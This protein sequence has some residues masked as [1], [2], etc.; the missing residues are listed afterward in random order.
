MSLF[1][2]D[3]FYGLPWQSALV[4]DAWDMLCFVAPS[5]ICERN[6]RC[7]TSC[8]LSKPV[9]QIACTDSPCAAMT[10]ATT[11]ITVLLAVVTATTVNKGVQYGP[12]IVQSD[13]RVISEEN[14]S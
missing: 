9:V 11:V 12:R 6:A 1:P 3:P 14:N 5:H 10:S 4:A 2:Q 13:G 7:I 8:W